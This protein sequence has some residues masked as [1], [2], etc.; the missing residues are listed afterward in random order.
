[1]QDRAA[2]TLHPDPAQV[3]APLGAFPVSYKY[4]LRDSDGVLTMEHGENRTAF[5][6]EGAPQPGDCVSCVGLVMGCRERFVIPSELGRPL[7]CPAIGR[8]VD[9]PF[10]LQLARRK[11]LW[12][13]LRWWS[14]ATAP[15]GTSTGGRAQGWLSRCLP[16]ARD[17]AS[18][19]ASSRT[20][21][22]WPTLATQQVCS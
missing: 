13:R 15:S 11:Q 14:S 1:M 5:L 2:L 22:S 3:R 9:W 6:P 17:A 20:S 4:A 21:S 12:C 10:V 7:Q 8:H 18:A 19:S 16:C